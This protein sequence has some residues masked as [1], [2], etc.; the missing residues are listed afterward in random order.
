MVRWFWE[1]A[2][3][4]SAEQRQALLRFATSCSRPPL[5]G[6]RYLQPVFTVRL[7][8]GGGEAGGMFAAVSSMFRNRP[9]RSKLPTA[10]TCFN[11]LKI[12][13]YR[14]KAVLRQK[15]LVAINAKTGF[16]LT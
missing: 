10:S 11:M 14:S 8:D 15:L 7:V 16:N 13:R 12:P 4:L 6:F 2:E 9:D 3:E 5:M 1:V